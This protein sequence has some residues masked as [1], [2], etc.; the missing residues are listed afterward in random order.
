MKKWSYCPICGNAIIKKESAL[1]CHRCGWHFYNNPLPAVAGF[2]MNEKEEILLVKRGVNPEMGRWA[3]PS[4]FVEQGETPEQAVIRELKEETGLN[5][6]C[7]NL[8]GVYV[9][10]T[11]IYGEIILLG[12]D[13]EPT[14]GKLK[15]GSDTTE[16]RFFPSRLLPNIPFLSHR[17]I[18]NKGIHKQP[19]HPIYVETLKSKITEATITNTVRF[20]KGSMGIDAKIMKE[21]NIKAGEKVHVLNYDNGERFETYVIAEKAGS[22]KFTLYG[23]ASLK[24]KKG[25]RLCILSY[26]YIPQNQL[27]LLKPRIVL[28][29]TK[30][31]IKKIKE[32]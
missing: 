20:Y 18:I 7:K 26:V 21:A 4:G 16:V 8:I 9:E 15:G 3:L 32:G 5:G 6:I 14:G 2:V 28:L 25:Q 24:G 29:D 17:A 13:I 10:Q 27:E 22:K 31:Q 12:Y 1:F 19:A 11:K 30:N 23:P